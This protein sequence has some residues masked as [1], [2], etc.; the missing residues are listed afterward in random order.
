[1]NP[2]MF[3]RKIHNRIIVETYEENITLN[4]IVVEKLK[5]SVMNFIFSKQLPSGK[6]W[7]TDR[8]ID[9]VEDVDIDYNYPRAVSKI[10]ANP[11]RNL[12]YIE[13]GAGLGE[14]I[15]KLIDAQIDKRPIVIDPAPYGI[16]QEMLEYILPIVEIETHYERCLKLIER[17]KLMQNAE[18]VNLINLTLKDAILQHPEIKGIGDILVDNYGGTIWSTKEAG[19]RPNDILNLEGLLL[20]EGGVSYTQEYSSIKKNG[21]MGFR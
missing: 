7:I 10:V 16:M 5:G 2:Q 19:N 4:Y 1:M 17:A 11:D 8:D 20:R 12:Q 14:F 15:Q 18:K 21:K 9:S 6:V 13:V 3:N